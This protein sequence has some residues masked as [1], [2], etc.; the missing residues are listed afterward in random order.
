MKTLIG[1]NSSQIVMKGDET[2]NICKHERIKSVNCRIFC[3]SCG[4]E[5]PLDY[6][7]VKQKQAAE[8]PENKQEMPI[9]RGRKRNG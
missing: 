3:I 9:K 5:L 7:F 1:R 4:E 2:M 8:K 6:L